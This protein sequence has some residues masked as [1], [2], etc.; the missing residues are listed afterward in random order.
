MLLASG[1]SA[2]E[3]AV[4]EDVR[5]QHVYDAAKTD[6]KALI[7]ELR[8]FD[9]TAQEWF[10]F[11]MYRPGEDPFWPYEEPRGYWPHPESDGWVWQAENEE[12]SIL[13]RNAH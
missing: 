2:A 8:G 1:L 4:L 5:L 3:R 10:G 7:A 11:T 6:P 12:G 13:R 9:P